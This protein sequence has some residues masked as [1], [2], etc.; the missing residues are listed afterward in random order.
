M[1]GI[2]VPLPCRRRT[3]NQTMVSIV[4]FLVFFAGEYDSFYPPEGTF[5]CRACGSPLYSAQ[6]KFKSGCGWPAFYAELPDTIERHEDVTFGMRRVEIT[7]KN[8]GGHLGHVFDG[9]GFD[10]PTDSRHCVNSLSIKFVPKSD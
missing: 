6:T 1:S 5:V 9:E 2:K 7:C 8:C 4:R 3:C 10:T